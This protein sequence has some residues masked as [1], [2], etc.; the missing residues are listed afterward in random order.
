VARTR[1]HRLLKPRLDEMIARKVIPPTV[2]VMPDAPWSEARAAGLP[3]PMM[4]AYPALNDLDGLADSCRFGRR[5]G[6]RGR[7]AVHPRQV[8]VIAS[9]FGASDDEVTWARQVLAALDG[10]GV[11]TLPDGS[12]VD[13]AMARRAEAILAR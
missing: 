3:P 8:P 9:V 5:L 4:S 6:M 7:T 12:M 10:A 13:A 2:V 11:A 1:M